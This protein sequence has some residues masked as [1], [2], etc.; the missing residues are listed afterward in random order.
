MAYR[1]MDVSRVVAELEAARRE[2]RELRDEVAELRRREA[3]RSAG[4]VQRAVMRV[5]GEAPRVKSDEDLM[6]KVWML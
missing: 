5:F 4:V 1:I 6:P 3:W 2:M